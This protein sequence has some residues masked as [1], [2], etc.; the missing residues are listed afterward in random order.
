MIHPADRA[1]WETA[2]ERLRATFARA[3]MARALRQPPRPPRYDEVFTEGTAY[4]DQLARED[5]HHGDPR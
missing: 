2:K 1:K 3:S 5:D 4:L